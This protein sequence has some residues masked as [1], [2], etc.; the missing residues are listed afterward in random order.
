MDESLPSSAKCLA[1]GAWESVP[2]CEIIK[3]P[4]PVVGQHMSVEISSLTYL[5][6][7]NYTCSVGYGIVSGEW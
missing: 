5:G 4:I 2:D 3:C 7:V 1:A 6:T